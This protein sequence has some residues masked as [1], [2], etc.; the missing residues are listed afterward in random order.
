[1]RSGGDLYRFGP[2]E[3]DSGRRRLSRGREPVALPDR[4]L[5]L[6]LLLASNPG[7]IVAKDALFEAGWRGTA[8]SDN[9]ITQAIKSLRK[10]LGIQ[11]DGEPYIKTEIGQGYRFVAS[12]ERAQPHQPD[13]PL[14]TL[15]VPYRAFVEGR[16]ALETF[17]LD[18]VARARQAFEHALRAAPDYPAAHIG[19][20]NAWVLGFESTRAEAAPDVGALQQAAYHAREGCRLDPS[21][22]D[23]WSTL[24]FVL[25]RIGDAR[26]ATAAVRK[27]I[28][29]EPEDW[30]H[31]VRLAFVSWGEERLRA[32]HRVLTL[33]PGLALAHWFAASV[34][35]ARQAFDRAIEHLREGCAARDAQRKETARFSAVG[36]HLLHGLVLAARGASDEALEEF[37]RELALEDA[38]HVYARECGANT[39]YAC[40]A[41][42]LRR[43]LRDQAAAAFHQAL[44]RVPSHA[45]AAIGLECAVSSS[46]EALT[47]RHDANTVDAAIVNAAILALKGKHPEAAGV[48]GEALA[49]A[50]PGSA[51]WLL[52]VEPLLYPTA[53][54]EVW[55]P[56]LAILRDRAA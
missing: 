35:V 28:G 44:K 15:L 10:A 49:H 19:M 36:L 46:L 18:S 54:R 52:A 40:G 38:G 3:L 16:A 4:H 56:T 39:W 11:N 12:V 27:A 42:R 21:S 8:V 23:A 26:A 25:H 7:H 37:E 6:L 43:G 41:L 9:S 29:L 14:D 2:F 47:T 33:C 22:G 31:Y 1:M 30:R 53:Y 13:V 24:A 34:F 55:A 50:D 45:M 20:A 51:G 32:A 17:D 5:E 48:C